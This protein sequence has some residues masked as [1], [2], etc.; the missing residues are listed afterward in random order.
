[1]NHMDNK[2][3]ISFLIS[4]CHKCTLTQTIDVILCGVCDADKIGKNFD[5]WI[6]KVFALSYSL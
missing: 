2:S 5:V 6:S 1:M 3:V 4:S